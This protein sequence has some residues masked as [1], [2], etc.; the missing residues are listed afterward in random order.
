[1]LIMHL[2]LAPLTIYGQGQ[3]A[4]TAVK[5]INVTSSFLKLDDEIKGNGFAVAVLY[6]F[7]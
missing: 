1:M 7:K 5:K 3:Y 6:M 4:L 2:I